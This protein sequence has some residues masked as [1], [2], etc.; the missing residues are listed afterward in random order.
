MKE[1][2]NMLKGTAASNGI[3]IGKILLLEEASLEYT[4]HE[5]T[6]IE[7]ELQRFRNAIDELAAET[8]K[9]AAALRES[10][11]E[12]EALI[13]EGHISL[14][15][16]PALKGETENMIQSGQCAEA[17]YEAMCDMFI[18]IFS[19]MEDE[20][21]R[22]RAADVRDIKAGLLRKLLGIR[23]IKVSDAPKG[24]VLLTKELTP[25]VTAGDRKSVV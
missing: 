2:K 23:E 12:K 22:Q 24:S 1:V 14:L 16:D 10:A 6:D 25:S 7:A 18:G 11:G 17:A 4:P 8:E 5:V 3:G 9:D 13:M 21:M 20:M 15:N 19:S